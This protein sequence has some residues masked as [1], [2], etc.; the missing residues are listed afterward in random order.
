MFTDKVF[1]LLYPNLGENVST[2]NVKNWI[3]IASISH[4]IFFQPSKRKID[5]QS[6]DFQSITDNTNKL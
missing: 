3:N 6:V 4:I 1:Y 5:L 2:E